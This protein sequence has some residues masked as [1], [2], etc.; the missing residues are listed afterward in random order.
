MKIMRIPNSFLTDFTR[1]ADLKLA[2]VFYSLIHRHTQRNMLGYVVTVKQE[3]LAALCGCSPATVK[4]SASVLRSFGFIKSQKR[5]HMGERLGTY[6]YVIAQYNISRNYFNMDKRLIRRVNGQAFRVYAMFCKLADSKNRTFFQSLN[7]LAGILS[8]SK[9][10]IIKA[11]KQLISLKLIRKRCKKTS[12]GDYTDNT[13]TV[14]I[15][16]RNGGIHKK[17][18]AP[19]TRLLSAFS[20]CPNVCEIY[21][22]YSI[23]DKKKN[24][25]HFSKNNLKKRRFYFTKGSIKNELSITN[26]LSLS[27]RKKKNII[28]VN[29]SIFII[30]SVLS[31]LKIKP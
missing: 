20:S 7:D 15:Y 10:E 19:V 23:A 4:R 28:Y 24:V 9:N 14:C 12:V 16:V 26:P 21:F 11:V 1:P 31:F 3:T 27:V 18:T 6:T 13:Y 8:M 30:F 17:I 25:K 2:C 29:L 5:T 22:I